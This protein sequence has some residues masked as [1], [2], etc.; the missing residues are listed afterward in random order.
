MCVKHF[1]FI[2]EHKISLTYPDLHRQFYISKRSKNIC[3]G[4]NRSL[5]LV[6]NNQEIISDIYDHFNSNHWKFKVRFVY[7][8]VSNTT[9]WKFD[10]II[11]KKPIC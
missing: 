6:T 5:L 2:L 3:M 8:T 7:L 4:L 11:Y 10:Y 9:K 1:L